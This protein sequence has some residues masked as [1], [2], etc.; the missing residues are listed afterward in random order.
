MNM[1]E[2][3]STSVTW[4]RFA[5]GSVDP[6]M[7]E[8]EGGVVIKCGTCCW[9]VT[10]V[11]TSTFVATTSP[12]SSPTSS[13]AS[14]PTSSPTWWWWIP[15]VIA[16][17]VLLVLCTALVCYLHSRRHLAELVV[18]DV[19]LDAIHP[20]TPVIPFSDFSDFYMPNM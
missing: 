19:P 16:A 13:P 4:W 3:C 6:V 20:V 14:S 9:E 8:S 18:Y 17:V 5:D 11:A 7:V 10:A 2:T 15:V 12:T 1:T